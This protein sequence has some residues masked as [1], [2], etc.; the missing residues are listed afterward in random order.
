ML[1]TPL[2]KLNFDVFIDAHQHGPAR[3]WSID[4]FGARWCPI[5]NRNGIWT[6]F[7]AGRDAPKKYKFSFAKERDYIMFTLRWL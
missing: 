3:K 6:M 5:E 2:T 1:R 4:H 7:W